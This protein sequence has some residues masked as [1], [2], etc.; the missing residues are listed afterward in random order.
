[1]TARTDGERLAVLESGMTNIQSEIIQLR[2]EIG[3]LTKSVDQLVQSKL[4]DHVRLT[5]DLETLK[6][7]VGRIENQNKPIN[8]WITHT[9]SA[10]VGAIL[11]SLIQFFLTHK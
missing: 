9:L 3:A 1:M 7:R 5:N 2:T 4:T 8:R 10:V 11:L 6:S